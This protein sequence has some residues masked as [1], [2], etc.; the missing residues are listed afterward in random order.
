MAIFEI[1]R[2][3][4]VSIYLIILQMCRGPHGS[5]QN[6]LHQYGLQCGRLRRCRCQEGSVDRGFNLIHI[7]QI[8]PCSGA[9]LLLIPLL[10]QI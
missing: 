4:Y 9:N 2:G 1:H 6:S 7:N 5:Q 10:W 8:R 3:L